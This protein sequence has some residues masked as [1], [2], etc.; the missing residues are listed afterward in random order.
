MNF[1]IEYV[2]KSSISVLY[3]RISTISG[4]SEWFADDVRVD[5]EGNYIF[6]WNGSVEKAK[7]V[8]KKQNEYI[9]FQWL[10]EETI[11]EMLILVNPIT[12]DVAL[13]VKD[14]ADDEDEKNYKIQNWDLQIQRLKKLLG[15]S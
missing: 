14:I 4:L 1:E 12:H 11:F 6:D 15:T 7:L 13:I 8:S 2:I 3:E 10:E 5:I 9:K